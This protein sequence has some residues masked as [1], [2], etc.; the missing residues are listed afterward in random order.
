[1]I[2]L[3]LELGDKRVQTFLK[4]ISLKVNMIAWQEFEHNYFVTAVQHFNHYT[5]EMT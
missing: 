5:N 3:N 2:L 1:M 4:A